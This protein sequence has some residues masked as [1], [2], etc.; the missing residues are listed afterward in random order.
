MFNSARRYTQQ[1]LGNI[2]GSQKLQFLI[3][4]VTSKCNCICKTCFYWGQL[5]QPDDLSFDEI[6]KT[7]TKLG[8]FHTLLLSGG[9]PFIRKDL[10]EVCELFI[11]NNRISVLAIPTNAVFT[12]N[13][14]QFSEKILTAY[15]HLTLSI[16]VSIDGFRE[17]HDEIRG[18]PGTFE[19]A[20]CTLREMAV[21][22]KR[23]PNLELVVNTVISEQTA[24]RLNELMD[25]IYDKFDIDFQDFELLRGDYRNKDLSLVPLEGVKSIHRRILINRKRWL[26]KTRMGFLDQIAVL[27]FLALSQERKERSIRGG[28]NFPVCCAGQNI[29]VI[30]ACGNVK[31]CELLPAVGNL[32]K[33]DF[34]FSNIAHSREAIRLKETVIQN[35]C[36]CTH[37]CF[38]KSTAAVSVL[39]PLRVLF[40]GLRFLLSK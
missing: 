18:I 9:E 13:I 3:F 37:V 14:V 26:R 39:S 21:L 30:E 19:K 27:G 32:K 10:F 12:K 28:K 17:I 25:F 24:P 6:Q 35:G 11:N 16:A 29:A 40:Y 34:C 7:S 33:S 2:F 5:N 36:H 23:H 1:Y 8:N 15:P 22:R 20:C 31:L 38:I 4:F